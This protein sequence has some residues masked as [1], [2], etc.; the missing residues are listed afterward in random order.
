[1][2]RYGEDG[3]EEGFFQEEEDDNTPTPNEIEAIIDVQHSLLGAMELDL[4]EQALNQE[5]LNTAIVL[6][7]Q[8]LWW[9]FRSSPKK[10]RRIEKIYRRL[11]LMI[12][13]DLEQ[14]ENK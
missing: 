6:A 10:I 12:H 11:I 7:R 14:K 2:N 8:D 9:L 5:L 1:M 13:K 4:A 3:Q